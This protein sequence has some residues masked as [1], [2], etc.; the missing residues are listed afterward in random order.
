MLNL[1]AYKDLPL[2]ID[3]TTQGNLLMYHKFD[4]AKMTA[5][6]DGHLHK[7]WTKLEENYDLTLQSAY[8]N[9]E[10]DFENV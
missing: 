4:E 9:S 3:I 2:I 5:N 10:C 7:A 1:V 8:V 6:S